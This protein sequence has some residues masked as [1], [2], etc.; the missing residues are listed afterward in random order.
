M[1]QHKGAGVHGLA[2]PI[3]Q[4]QENQ[5]VEAQQKEDDA[6]HQAFKP[7][8][9]QAGAFFGGRG[10]GGGL[11]DG[12]GNEFGGLGIHRQINRGKTGRL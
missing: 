2:F 12:A 11:G 8:A 7:A 10:S 6:P 1:A 4:E 9:Q 3:G 5:Q